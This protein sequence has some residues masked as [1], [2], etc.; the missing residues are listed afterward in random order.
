M[1]NSNY[2]FI[3]KKINK[4]I[5]YKCNKPLNI[6]N[7]IILYKYKYKHCNFNN[8]IYSKNKIYQISFSNINIIYHHIILYFFPLD[9]YIKNKICFIND[10]YNNIDKV[11]NYYFQY[12]FLKKDMINNVKLTKFDIIY[13]TNIKINN[14]NMNILLN[15]I[16]HNL[17]EGGNFNFI[18]NNNN[19]FIKIIYILLTF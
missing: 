14:E 3:T 7:L 15:F 4:N 13:M 18:I 1:S 5:F 11:N 12:T 9:F 2:N 8:Y 10:Y 19:I 6:D 16:N 17:S